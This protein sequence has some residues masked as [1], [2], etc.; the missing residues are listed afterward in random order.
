[1]STDDAQ[2]RLREPFP[3]S[4]IGYQYRGD[5]KLAYV[6]HAAVTQRL[7]EVDPAWSWEPVALDERG[8]PLFDPLGGL[9]IRLTIAG[10][11]R[12]GYGDAQGKKG[13]NAVKECIGDAIR[14]AAMRFGVALDL[15]AKEDI[16]STLPAD[17]E[18]PGT[19]AADRTVETLR[20][21]PPPPIPASMGSNGAWLNEPSGSA[22]DAQRRKITAQL[23][24]LNV[25]RDRASGYVSD[26]IKRD[27]TST[28]ELS[29]QEAMRLIDQ[30]TK[31]IETTQQLV[32]G[33]S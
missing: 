7:L 11:T 33:G 15:W 1:M 14:N 4:A 2:R 13:P 31:T 6:G 19:V 23:A 20:T 25:S 12:L 18:T 5:V 27:I 8:L 24:T 26:L 32:A 17:V 16:S 21:P 30:L 10:I 9:W 22:T 3:K 28:S 29:K